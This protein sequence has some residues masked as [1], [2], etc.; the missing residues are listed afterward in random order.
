[1]EKPFVKIENWAVVQRGVDLRY[2]ELQPGRRLM[3]SVFGEASLPPKVI[4]TTPILRV[5]INKGLVETRNTL[6]QLGEASDAYKSWEQEQRQE[7]VAA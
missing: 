4:Y 7:E 2:K 1:M 6:Y 3:G 5:D